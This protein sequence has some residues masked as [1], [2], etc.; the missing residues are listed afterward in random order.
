MSDSA[1]KALDIVA[2][3]GGT[4]RT[5]EALAAGIHPRTLYALRDNGALV[6]V[7]RGV[8]RLAELPPPGDPDLALVAERIPHAVICLISALSLHELTSQIPHQI[9]IAIP[10]T[11]R[12]PVCREVPL[13]VHR[14]A[15]PS[16]TAGV[17]EHDI[18]GA[19]V[20]AYDKEKTIADCFKFRNKIGIDIVIEALNTYRHQ[21]GA[22]LQ[23]ILGYAKIN[24]VGN[25]IRP[26][27]E[28][29][30]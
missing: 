2:A 23:T 21:R 15:D 13:S 20:R 8:Y 27:L 4:I 11:A 22:S 1:S 25:T 26:Y 14:F 24:R 30:S 16:Y 7:T 5:S 6:T 12:T 10:H 28:A 3:H 18:G 17:I 9:H 19:I 29:L